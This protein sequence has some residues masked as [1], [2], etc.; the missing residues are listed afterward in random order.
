MV[1]GLNTGSTDIINAVD[2]S[3]SREKLEATI[4][5]SANANAESTME[6]RNIWA[7]KMAGCNETYHM[8]FAKPL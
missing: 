5:H 1:A 7:L 3:Y 4:T 6:G 8:C 2:M